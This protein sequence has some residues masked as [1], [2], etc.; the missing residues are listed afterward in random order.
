MYLPANVHSTHEQ[1]R[2]YRPANRKPWWRSLWFKLTLGVV[3]AACIA[4]TAASVYVSR[5]AGPILRERIIETLA[6]RFHSPVELDSVEVSLVRGVEV[7]GHGLR[8]LYIAGPNLPDATQ[9]AGSP[10]LKPMV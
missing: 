6:A 7:R 5:H 1:P 2:S 10:T 9:L 4:L 3:V 8:V